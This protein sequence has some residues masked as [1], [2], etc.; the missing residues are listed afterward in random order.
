MS[1]TRRGIPVSTLFLLSV[2]PGG[3]LFFYILPAL[4]SYLI[5][6]DNYSLEMLIIST[7]SVAFFILVL[8]S[9]FDRLL[10]PYIPKKFY[11][12]LVSVSKIIIVTYSI[13]MLYTAITAPSIPLLDALRGSSIDVISNGRETF[14]RTRT[15]WE[16]LLNYFFAMYRSILM[17][18]AICWLFYIKSN[19]RFTSVL[20]FLMTLLLTLEKSVCVIALIPLFF[21]FFQIKPKIARRILYVTIL[22]VAATSFLARGGVS[23][24]TGSSDLSYVPTQYNM[25]KSDSQIFY[26]LNRVL[27]IPYATSVDWLRYRDVKLGG[28]ELMGRNISIV[29]ALNGEE[30]I[31][32][33][34]EVFAFQWGQNESGTGSANTSYFIDAYI[35]WGVLGVLLYNLII[36]FIIRVSI[37]SDIFVI[38]ACTFVPLIFLLFNSLSAM[39]FS[40]GLFILLFIGLFLFDPTQFERGRM[41]RIRVGD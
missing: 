23:T 10:L 19:W 40:G 16:S 15:G 30:K 34:R 11:I 22:L 39:L 35:N 38:K 26:V 17:P 5:N 6:G 32:I 1:Q 21:L 12:D 18:F 25:F 20:I 28:K 33:E 8:L 41:N 9:N 29:A 2:I 27:F 36:V 14:L 3:T 24:D 13:L 31:N 37:R 7:V 4:L